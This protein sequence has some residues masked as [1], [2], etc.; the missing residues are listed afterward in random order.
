MYNKVLISDDFDS[1][2]QG[3]LAITDSLGIEDVTKVQYCDDAYLKIKR[4]AKDNAPFDL[5]ITDLSFKSDHRTQRYG[6]GEALIK[7]LHGEQPDLKIIVYSVEDRLQK[8]RSLLQLYKISAFV[9]KGRKGL[10]ELTHALHK[11]SAGKRYLSPQ[12]ANALN[13]NKDL[14]IDDYDIEL[15]RLL[16]AGRSQ[17]EISSHFKNWA[18]SPSSLSSIEKRLNRLRIQFK[19]NNAIHLVAITKDLG[20]I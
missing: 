13:N 6:S 19:A 12:I 5:L 11:V 4:A 20:I 7:V 8:V 14:E 9:C 1:I 15:I 17:E 2:N 18:I 3:I 16:A 10:V